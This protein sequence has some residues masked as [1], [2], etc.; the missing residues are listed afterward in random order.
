M[1]GLISIVYLLQ[2]S[3]QCSVVNTVTGVG[4]VC[5]VG[6]KYSFSCE[7]SQGGNGPDMIF[8]SNY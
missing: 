5:I 8:Y 6:K 7:G 3:P 1:G 2:V 4:L